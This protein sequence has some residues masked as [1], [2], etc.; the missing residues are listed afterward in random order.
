MFTFGVSCLL[1]WTP[2][3]VA[4][5][6]DATTRAHRDLTA[7]FIVGG[8]VA[9]IAVKPGAMVKAGQVLARLDDALAMAAL[10]LA[11]LEATSDVAVRVARTR[12]EIARIELRRL[13][14]TSP[15]SAE[16]QLAEADVNLAEL[17]VQQAEGQQELAKARFRQAQV[18]HE[19]HTLRAPFAGVVER[20][21]AGAGQVLADQAPV[22]RLVHDEVLW[23]D[24]DVPTDLTYNLRV[25]AAVKIV[26]KTSE[27][28][29]TLAGRVMHLSSVVDAQTDTR[30]VRLSV[31]HGGKLLTGAHVSLHLSQTVADTGQGPE[32]VHAN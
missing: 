12:L 3:T 14:A 13:K 32:T 31:T 11:R 18:H 19:Q 24:A 28:D 25:G 20:V 22:L 9:E 23:I 5:Q 10:D 21:F 30:R 26:P 15:G 1:A 2:L 6:I 16:S 27:S 8:R 17:V 4:A 7:A 29:V